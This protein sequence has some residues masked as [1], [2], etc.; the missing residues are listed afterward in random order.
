MHCSNDYANDTSSKRAKTANRMS[1][2][3]LVWNG[4]TV[5]PESAWE[6]KSQNATHRRPR[7]NTN[8]AS[9]FTYHTLT[10][11]LLLHRAENEAQMRGSRKQRQI[12]FKKKKKN[13]SWCLINY[14]AKRMGKMG[15]DG[16][17]ISK[18]GALGLIWRILIEKTIC[19]EVGRMMECWMRG[20]EGRRA[21]EMTWSF[22][23]GKRARCT[24]WSSYGPRLK[25]WYAHIGAHEAYIGAGY[26]KWDAVY[27]K[28]TILRWE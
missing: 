14:G 5:L 20:D 27:E 11:V 25:H 24:S 15:M 3:V 12:L 19:T 22:P 21:W 8:A 16:N 6:R 4:W 10:P 13:R 17:I 9:S 26:D 28:L 18:K 1:D 7:M 23:A 2:Y